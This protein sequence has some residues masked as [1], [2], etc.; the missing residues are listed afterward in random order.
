MKSKDSKPW[1][2]QRYIGTHAA[3]VMLIYIICATIAIVMLR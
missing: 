1:R 3:I 2:F